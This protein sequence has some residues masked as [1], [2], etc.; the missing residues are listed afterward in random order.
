MKT[1]VIVVLLTVI[2]FLHHN[3]ASTVGSLFETGCCEGFNRTRIPK[4]RIK[5]IGK[6]PSHCRVNASVITTV[7]DKKFCIDPNWAKM[8]EM[9]IHFNKTGPSTLKCNN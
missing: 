4:L 9:L 7:C 1:L 3:S 6:T 2:C 8:K 5:H